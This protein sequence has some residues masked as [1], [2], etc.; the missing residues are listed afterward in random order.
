[1]VDVKSQS[2]SLIDMS[3]ISI[4][5]MEKKQTATKLRAGRCCRWIIST[6]FSKKKTCQQKLKE[7]THH[8]KTYLPKEKN[9]HKKLFCPPFFPLCK[10]LPAPRTRTSNTTGCSGGYMFCGGSARDR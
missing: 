9:S 1:M 2:S 6:Q 5:M 8:S 7:K 10:R 4:D 3:F